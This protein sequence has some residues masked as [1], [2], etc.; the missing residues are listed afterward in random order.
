MH[1][2]EANELWSTVAT[3]TLESIRVSSNSGVVGACMQSGEMINIADAHSDDRFNPE[4]DDSTGFRTRSIIV[5]PVVGGD[6]KVAAAIQMIN[7]RNANG[8]HGVFEKNDEKLLTMLGSHVT[9]FIRIV[10]GD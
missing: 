4:V 5:I 1:N 8:S 7:K 6:G 9:C 3:G 10:N 2:S